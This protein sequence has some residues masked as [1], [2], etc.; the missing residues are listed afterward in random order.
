MGG[1]EL[2]PGSDLDLVFIYDTPA[3]LSTNGDRPLDNS[4][5][6]TR[7]GQR[8]IHILTAQTPMG[9]LYEVDMRLRPSGESGLLVTSL[10]AFEQYQHNK[11]WTWEH[12]ALVRARVVAGDH[13][14][15]NS[16]AAIRKTI[17]G[18]VR[19]EATLRVEVADMRK[20]M[21]EHMLPKGLESAEPPIFHLKHGTGAI[22]DIE[23]MVQYAVLAWTHQYPALADYSDNIRILQSLQQQGLF[24]EAQSHALTEAYKAY[25]SHAHRL[26]LL[27][28]PQEVPMADY[29]QYREAVIAMWLELMA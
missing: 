27:Q 6:Y 18:L 29:R 14:L 7:L 9:H 13:S 26:S 12:Q 22:V 1:I 28:Q 24:T 21:R 25:R 19:N 10:S 17:L 5:F 4:M 16:F 23:F 11:A 3:N 2:G 15:A 20:K 8:I